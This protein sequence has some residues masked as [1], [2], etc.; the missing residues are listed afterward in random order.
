MMRQYGVLTTTFAQSASYKRQAQEAIK[1]IAANPNLTFADDELRFAIMK[2]NSSFMTPISQLFSHL[3]DS[4]KMRGALPFVEIYASAPQPPEI[5]TSDSI[6]FD[7]REVMKDL[8]EKLSG[9]IV[10]LT[11]SVKQKKGNSEASYVIDDIMKIH[12]L[13]VRAALCASYQLTHDKIWLTPKLCNFIIKSYN[14]I[15]INQIRALYHVTDPILLK[16]LNFLTS[17][18][19]AQ[20][21]DSEA[22]IGNGLPDM[23]YRIGN[24][25]ASEIQ[26]MMAELSQQGFNY[27][28][29]YNIIDLCAMIKALGGEKFQTFDVSKMFRLFTAGTIDKAYG[30]I[31]MEYPPFWVYQILSIGSGAKHP[32]YNTIFK[33]NG[34]LKEIGAFAHD[35]NTTD[36]FIGSLGK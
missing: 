33:N 24:W 20:M 36:T 1:F 16:K 27:D 3:V 12:G 4:F 11:N 25:T 8:P 28:R 19:C 34:L 17:A 26:G 6:T 22:Q 32:V 7:T 10:N 15:I 2:S 35:L 23:M 5:F 13:Y 30:A 21:L 9:T 18:F 14:M 29:K 31:S